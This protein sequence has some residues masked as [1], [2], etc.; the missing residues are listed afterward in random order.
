MVKD[1]NQTYAHT[2]CSQLLLG[3]KLD[4]WEKPSL[5]NCPHQCIDIPKSQYCIM[6]L[7][8]KFDIS[9]YQYVSHFTINYNTQCS[10]WDFAIGE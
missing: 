1:I 9:I 2:A 8:E 6:I 10:N 7:N 3:I 4:K 5:L